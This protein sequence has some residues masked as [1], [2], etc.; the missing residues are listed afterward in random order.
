MRPETDPSVTWAPAPCRHPGSAEQLPDV[1]SDTAELGRHRF[2]RVVDAHVTQPQFDGQSHRLGCPV[3]LPSPPAGP[4]QSHRSPLPHRLAG[5]SPTTRRYVSAGRATRIP[6]A[7]RRSDSDRRAAGG[8]QDARHDP[9]GSP[10][11]CRKPWGS[12][13]AGGLPSRRRVHAPPDAPQFLERGCA[14]S[15]RTVPVLPTPVLT[16]C[17][18]WA[19]RGRTLGDGRAGPRLLAPRWPPTRHPTG[20]CRPIAPLICSGTPAGGGGRGSCADR[21]GSLGRRPRGHRRRWL[22]RPQPPQRVSRA[23]RPQRH[24]QDHP[25]RQECPQLP[26]PGPGALTRPDLVRSDGG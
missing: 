24:P 17:H 4:D 20:G 22:R 21:L 11:S 7:S 12:M 5:P 9:G 23:E 2:S 25:P 8:R 6:G 19:K 10:G 15:T 26:G 1:G 18:G 16:E 14:R 3:A 13:A